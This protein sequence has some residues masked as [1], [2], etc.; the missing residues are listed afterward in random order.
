MLSQAIE[1]YCQ[2]IYLTL[3]NIDDASPFCSL[4]I[5]YFNSGWINCLAAGID[6]KNDKDLD[7]LTSVVGYTQ[8]MNKTT[9]LF[10]DGS[11]TDRNGLI[12]LSIN[13]K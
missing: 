6:S 2:N 1:R 12:F 8:L 13:Q 11:Y 3:T 4:V 5:G 9:H 10:G 7:F